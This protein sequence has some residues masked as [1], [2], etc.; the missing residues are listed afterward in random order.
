MTTLQVM[1][2]IMAEYINCASSDQM[3]LTLP[4]LA[5]I[6]YY[7]SCWNARKIVGNGTFMWLGIDKAGASHALGVV[8]P[9]ACI[10]T[11]E[12]DVF[13]FQRNMACMPRII[14]LQSLGCEVELAEYGA[15]CFPADGSDLPDATLYRKVEPSLLNRNGGPILVEGHVRRRAFGADRMKA[16]RVELDRMTIAELRTELAARV[17]P[18]A[19]RK[20]DVVMRLREAIVSHSLLR[21]SVSSA[22]IDGGTRLGRRGRSASSAASRRGR[23]VATNV[24]N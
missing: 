1:V 18:V 16:V 21:D 11:N 19:G 15:Y 20:S 23:G 3:H 14:G 8:V 13:Y 4:S 6:S 12:G 24:P 5:T 9:L 17:L 10:D 7:V 22:A 2:S